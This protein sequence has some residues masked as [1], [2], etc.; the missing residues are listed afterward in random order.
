[1]LPTLPS[2]GFIERLSRYKFIVLLANVDWTNA[3]H[4]ALWVCCVNMCA[5]Y[6]QRKATIVVII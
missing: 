6:W 5:N 1:M 2:Q 3:I 4:V